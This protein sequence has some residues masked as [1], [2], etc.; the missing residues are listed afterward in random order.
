LVGVVLAE[1]LVSGTA[2]R[3]LLGETRVERRRL[4]NYA[5][6]SFVLVAMLPVLALAAVDSRLTAAKQQAEGG[7]RLHEASAALAG[8]IDQY[9]G[10]H[11]RAVQ[12]LTSAL[13]GGTTT[14]ADR[15]RLLDD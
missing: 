9:V 5:F 2:V 10:D 7:A 12:S 11:A 15:R 6:H 3:K 1:L 8:H 13:T 4:R 14:S